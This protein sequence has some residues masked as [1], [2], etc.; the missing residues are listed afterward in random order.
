ML[1][2]YSM[3]RSVI[4]LVHG[5]DPVNV[6]HIGAHLGEEIASYSANN[7]AHV[8]WFEAN[9]SLINSLENHVNKFA[10][11][12]QIVNCALWESNE[13]LKFNIANNGQSSSL[14]ALG[15]HAEH[16]PDIVVTESS[17]IDAYRFDAII[18][19]GAVRVPPIHFINIDTQGSEL[20]ILRGFG[21]M[22]LDNPVCGVYLEVNSEPLYEGIPLVG[23]IDQFLLKRNFFRMATAWTGAGWGDAF[24][25]KASEIYK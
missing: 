8:T 9:K 2:D 11:H 3:C 21:S 13:K 19:S 17:E 6:V 7:V 10:V 18:R 4:Q 5:F 20:S 23:E 14:F 15:T 22:L 24:Y 1:I 12:Q 16:Y 25:L